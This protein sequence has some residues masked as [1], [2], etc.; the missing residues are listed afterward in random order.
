MATLSGHSKCSR[1]LGAQ[2]S[3]IAEDDLG[4]TRGR[5]LLTLLTLLALSLPLPLERSHLSDGVWLGWVVW[6]GWP[7]WCGVV[8]L[9]CPT[10]CRLAC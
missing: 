1:L 5:T 6:C 10:G 4:W 2:P 3:A 9:V 7:G 8:W